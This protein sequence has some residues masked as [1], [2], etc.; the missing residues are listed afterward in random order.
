MR[1]YRLSSVTYQ[2]EFF[3]HDLIKKQKN[4]FLYVIDIIYS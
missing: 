2:Y 4:I 3:E 1:V